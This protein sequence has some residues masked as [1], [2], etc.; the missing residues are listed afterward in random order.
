MK[1]ELKLTILLHPLMRL[2]PDILER[3]RSME[4]ELFEK[5]YYNLTR[6]ELIDMFDA[7]EF[8]ISDGSGSCYEAIIRECKPL[9]V[10]GMRSVPSI[11][12]FNDDL[13][14]EYFP[15]PEYHEIGSYSYDSEAFLKEYFSY[16]YTGNR[17]EVEKSGRN[18]ILSL[19]F[20]I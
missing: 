16:L 6:E 18:E 5:V 11:E 12:T 17:K 1:K 3:I 9:T 8:V 7:H 10:K 15:F 13:E 4:G 2:D 14:E 20:L 19:D